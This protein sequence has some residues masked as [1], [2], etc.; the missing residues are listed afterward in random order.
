MTSIK[1]LG[2][3]RWALLGLLTVGVLALLA[4]C[5]GG[6]ETSAPTAEPTATLTPDRQAAGASPVAKYEIINGMTVPPE[7]DAKSN[8]ATLAGVDVNANGVRDDV[9]RSVASSVATTAEFDNAI[10][11]AKTYQRVL[12]SGL[13][14]QADADSFMISVGC[15]GIK[16]SENLKRSAIQAMI[17]NTRDRT[18]AFRANTRS[19]AGRIM[20]PAEDCKP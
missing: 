18:K 10:F 16:T 17:L 13:S 20:T 4:A 6:K 1:A 5:G 14:S 8:N 19:F 12:V 3:T 7:P 15:A 11:I 2:T 9:E